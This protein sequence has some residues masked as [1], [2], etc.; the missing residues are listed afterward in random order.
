[1]GGECGMRANAN[2][3]MRAGNGGARTNAH[4]R[5]RAWV[6]GANADLRKQAGARVR[7]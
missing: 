2:L 1:M 4:L 7:E 5:V 3:R 6:Q